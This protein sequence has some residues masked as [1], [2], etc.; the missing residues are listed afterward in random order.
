MENLGTLEAVMGRPLPVHS[1]TQ[2]QAI[3]DAHPFTDAMRAC[4]GQA[5]AHGITRLAPDG[6]WV[7]TFAPP[8]DPEPFA[9]RWL[10]E[11]MQ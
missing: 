9:H 8:G 1:R 3:A 6:E 10:P 5:V 2:L 4:W 7:E 11:W